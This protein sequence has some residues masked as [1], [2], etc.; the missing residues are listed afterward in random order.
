MWRNTADPLIKRAIVLYAKASYGWDNQEAPRF[1]N[2]Y[3]LLKASLTLSADYT[4]YISVPGSE[5]DNTFMDDVA[6]DWGDQ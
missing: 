2:S 5:T 6:A 1:Q 4:N 3:D